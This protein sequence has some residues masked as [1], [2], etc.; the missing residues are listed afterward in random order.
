PPT[1]TITAPIDGAIVRSTPYT[2]TGTVSDSTAIV[3]VNGALAVVTGNNFSAHVVLVPGVNSIQVAAENAYG[4]ASRT[5]L[6]T[7]DEDLAPTI[8]VI[9]PV[10][11]QV[12]TK[13]EVTVQGT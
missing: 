7:F 6:V 2:V 12:L 9:A 13:P 8:E 3:K 1:L 11:G 5:I 4:S 10:E